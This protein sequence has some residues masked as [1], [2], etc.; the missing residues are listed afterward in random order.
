MTDTEWGKLDTIGNI[1]LEIFL[2]SSKNFNPVY[3]IVCTELTY[4]NRQ[5]S[6]FLQHSFGRGNFHSDSPQLLQHFPISSLSSFL[7]LIHWNCI[8]NHYFYCSSLKT[9]L[10]T[11]H[12]EWVLPSSFLY[13]KSNI[14]YLIKTVFFLFLV[15]WA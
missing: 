3:Q 2:S 11:F 15:K 10:I 6:T 13:C 5:F 12:P 9:I 1:T 14:L 8:E 7:N 4:Q